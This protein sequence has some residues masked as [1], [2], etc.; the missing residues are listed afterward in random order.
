MIPICVIAGVVIVGDIDWLDDITPA[1]SVALARPKSS[2][3]TVPSVRNLD[4]RGLQVPVD[5]PQLVSGFQGLGYLLRDRQ[6]LV[7]WNP[8]SS[9]S[10]GER[11]PLHQLH[12][13]RTA[14]VRP[15]QAVDLRDVRMVQRCQR[16]GFTLETCQPLGVEGHSFRQHFNRDLPSEV[17]IRRPI[18]LSHAPHADKGGDF[19]RAEVSTNG[20]RHGKWLRL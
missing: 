9:N 11:L 1:G 7:D 3:L 8:A 17:R 10:V 20:Q 14:A 6:C 12:H 5:D 15:F 19:I 2:T 4:V 18:H 13:E 16:L